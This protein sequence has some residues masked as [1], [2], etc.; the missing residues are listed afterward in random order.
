MVWYLFLSTKIEPLPILITSWTLLQVV[1]YCIFVVSVSIS[2]L[3]GI[4]STPG[5]LLFYIA[6]IFLATGVT[7]NCSK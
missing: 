2:S 3:E 4:P 1:V 6:S 7:I 5:D